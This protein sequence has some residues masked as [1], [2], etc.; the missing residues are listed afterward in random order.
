MYIH[1]PPPR[2]DL[3]TMLKTITLCAVFVLTSLSAYAK[4]PIE[5]LATP[6]QIIAAQDALKLRVERGEGE[7][8]DLQKDDRARLFASQSTVYR[9]LDRKDTIDALSAPQR[10]ELVNALESINAITA[11]AEDDRRICERVKKL[12]TNRIE[13]VCMTVAQRRKLREAVEREGLSTKD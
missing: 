6:Q 7:F 10:V 2:S 13:N 1:R 8:K 3:P 9:L 12:G 5:I 4:E 11:Q